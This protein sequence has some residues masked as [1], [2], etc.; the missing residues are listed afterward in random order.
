[1]HKLLGSKA[2]EMLRP[3]NICQS[4]QPI[5]LLPELSGKNL[6]EELQCISQILTGIRGLLESRIQGR[7]P[8]SQDPARVLKLLVLI[9]FLYERL[10]NA[11]VNPNAINSPKKSKPVFKK[12]GSKHLK[13]SKESK[14]KSVKPVK[15]RVLPKKS[16]KKK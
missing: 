10:E 7:M 2:R 16:Q 5:L 15:K 9:S 13:K 14:K 6:L 11:S 8:V 1:L 12:S 3:E 4:S